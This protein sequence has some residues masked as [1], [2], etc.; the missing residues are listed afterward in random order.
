MASSGPQLRRAIVVGADGA[1]GAILMNSLAGA[2]W[3][4]YGTSR[5]PGQDR[6]ALDLAAVP[7]NLQLPQADVC[8]ICAGM[9]N[10]AACQD[11]EAA[12]R[13]VNV[14]GT[15]LIARTLIAR[16]TH[17]VYLSSDSV[18]DGLSPNQSAAS[19]THPRNNYGRQKAEAERAILEMGNAAVLRMTKVLT[20]ENALLRG[21]IDALRQGSAVTAFSD[22][23]M[24]PIPA[25]YVTA[26]L[27]AIAERS[28]RGIF[29]ISAT[30]DVTYLEAARHIARRLGAPPSLVCE[31]KAADRHIPL[32]A[33]PAHTSLDSSR[34]SALLRR[35][36]PGA[37]D[38]IDQTFHLANL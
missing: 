2:G 32:Y 23:V 10:Q 18:F 22:M 33:R 13:K 24:A 15:T 1:I 37:L 5:R 21:W 20:A 26:L 3:T 31:G 34:A 19:P 9:T 11:N 27:L 38:A 6:I 29:Q 28:E 35:E 12:S 8:F 16:G 4:A 30:R 17:V 7:E 14:E 25:S 36:M